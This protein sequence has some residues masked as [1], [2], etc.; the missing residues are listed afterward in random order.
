MKKTRVHDAEKNAEITMKLR[1]KNQAFQTHAVASILDCFAGQPRNAGRYRIEPGAVSTS[2]NRRTGQ[3]GIGL[4]RTLDAFKNAEVQ[5]DNDQLLSNIRKVQH[6]Q[7]LPLSEHLATSAGCHI[8]LDVEME[9]GTGKTYCYIKTLFEMHRHFG[10]SKF[11]VVVPSIAIREG[12]LKSF[13]VTA[14]H[15]SVEYKRKARFFAYN[16]RHLQHLQS[17]SSDDGVNV[18][19]INIQAFNARGRD[20]RRIY[21]SLDE[22][23]SR[24][25][26]DVIGSNRPILILDEPQKMEGD[27]TLEALEKFKPLM[28]LRYS[29]THRKVRNQV[30]RLDALDAYNQKLVKRISVKGITVRGLPGNSGYLYLESIET[31]RGSPI[32]RMEFERR[33]VG[34]IKRTL[35]R[36]ELGQNLFDESNRL[37]Q[38]RGYLISDIDARTNTVRFSNGLCLSAGE[39]I[40]DVTE[41]VLRR[42]QIRETIKA[43]IER[44]K[45]LFAKGIKVLSLFFIDEVIKYRDYERADSQGEYAKIFEEEY[46]TFQQQMHNKLPSDSP[47]RQYLD[48]I[49][50]NDTHKGYFSIDKRHSDRFIDPKIK[51]RGEDKGISDDQ[52][53]YDLILKDKERL[54]S[55]SEPTRF[56]FSHSALRE[57]WDN[58]N[59]FVMCMLKHSDSNISRRQEVG[60]GLRI[61]VNQRGERMDDPLRVHDIN[62]LTVVASESYGDF[63]KGLQGELRDSLSARPKKATEQY[64]RNKVIRTSASQELAIDP[65]MATRIHRWL[66]RHEYIDDD[67]QITSVY[68]KARTGDALAALPDDL[69]EFTDSIIAWVDTV[70]SDD[71]IPCPEN[72]LLSKINPLNENFERKGFRDLWERI[73]RK[74]V[75]RVNMDSEAVVTACVQAINSSLKVTRLQYITRTGIQDDEVT[76]N[77]IEAGRGFGLSATSIETHE[78]PVRSEVK[79]DLVGKV[80]E[81][82]HLTRKTVAEVLQSIKTESFNLFKQNPE[83]FIVECIRLISEQVAR[84]VVDNISYKPLPELYSIDIFDQSQSGRLVNQAHD[85]LTR[86]I[87]DYVAT[88]SDVEREFAR[89]L[90]TCEQVDVYAKL[91]SGYS[92]P[93]PVGEY[94]PDW[95]IS[96]KQNPLGNL[97]FVVETKGSLRDMDLREIEK[98]KIRCAHKFFECL[99]TGS[100]RDQVKF[101]TVDS[102]EKLMDIAVQPAEKSG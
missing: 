63:V 91:P 86:H 80:A 40:G 50:V 47:Y 48:G 25:P 83:Q 73:N 75:Y 98:S 43:H 58:P 87:Y 56:I 45:F 96:F 27:N 17:Y 4:E 51:R 15:F 70:L 21:D 60:R 20:Q 30:H 33:Q 46:T 67:D 76:W 7:N 24:R 88:D 37:D 64:F 53:A 57:G 68:R 74:A 52:D 22:F 55:L 78:G 44:E 79:Y 93:T 12:V 32:A 6:R 8:N 19:V 54:L 101:D 38:Y 77:H 29:A 5:L 2:P 92:I 82:T 95:A 23:Q 61:C 49:T 28:V 26:I 72:E 99:T 13:A 31:S 81:G 65:N 36:L 66:I 62:T 10:W 11:I 39:A 42:I 59:V 35:N 90:D 97:Y 1:F 41:T 89:N 100:G 14:E 71:Q 34:G 84:L 69:S 94:N 18:M 16:S 9:T 3:S 102:F 85:K